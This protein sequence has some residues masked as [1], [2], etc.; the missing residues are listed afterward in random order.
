MRNALYGFSFV[1]LVGLIIASCTDPKEAI[2]VRIVGV[3]TGPIHEIV[4]ATGRVIS[5]REIEIRSPVSGKLASVY[6]NEGD[7]ITAGTQFARFDDREAR[8]ALNQAKANVHRA[9]E[10]KVHAER[11][12]ERARRLFEVGGEA[13]QVVEDAKDHFLAAQAK[14]RDLTEEFHLAKMAYEKLRI[15]SPFGGIVTSR[16]AQ[17]GEWVG[18]GIPLFVLVDPNQLQIEAKINADDSGAVAI[19][20][21]ALIS[22]DAFS[23]QTL[24]ERVTRIAPAVSKEITTNTVSV[25]ISLGAQMPLKIGQ[26][27]DV[28]IQ[29][30][31]KEKALKVP[32]GAITIHEGTPKVAVVRDG[33]VLWIS[34]GL[35]IKDFTH[36]EIVSGLNSTEQ[37]I[38]QEEKILSEGDRVEP[39]KT[40]NRT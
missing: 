24:T 18:Q 13:Q 36:V 8:S 1:F 39:L 32:F 16:K 26:Q 21:T 25:R 40:E 10:E 14:K 2:P 34:V 33:R 9:Q 27:I 22:S 3:E 38:L 35:G 30:R 4:A 20:Q 5:R 23:G 37:V 31:S 19:G 6:V 7:I 28:K 11:R 12:L 17:E 29:T 15:V